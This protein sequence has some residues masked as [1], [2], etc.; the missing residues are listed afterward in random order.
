MSPPGPPPLS[1]FHLLLL[2]TN[3]HS[4]D[5]YG[6]ILKQRDNRKLGHAS[7]NM[8]KVFGRF[9]FANKRNQKDSKIPPI[10]PTFQT[11]NNK[12]KLPAKSPTSTFL[13]PIIIKSLNKSV[14]LVLQTRLSPHWQHLSAPPPPAWPAPRWSPAAPRCPPR[15]PAGRGGRRNGPT[16]RV[17]PGRS[18][19][20]S[21]DPNFGCK[22]LK[23]HW[24]W[25]FQNIAFSMLLVNVLQ[26]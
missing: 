4:W 5:S 16:R 22:M 23:K 14:G 24:I 17:D 7:Q 25:V 1:Y 26:F 3:K 18:S 8:C 10:Q 9:F 12:Q 11:S 19:S 13:D 2:F 21:Q 20:G 6:P 15:R